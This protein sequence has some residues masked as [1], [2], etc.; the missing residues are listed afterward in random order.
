MVIS[1]LLYFYLFDSHARD[2]NGMPDPNGT[3]VV[4]KF[5][6]ALELEQYLY[7]LSIKLHANLYEIVPV[8]VN[9]S[10][11]A[12]QIL[13]KG[14]KDQQYHNCS[15]ENKGDKGA[16]LQEES[17][18]ANECKKRW[19]ANE[20]DL[21]RQN[22]LERDRLHKKLKRSQETDYEKQIRL[23]KNRLYKSKRR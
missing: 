16:T 3:A 11:T 18:K 23:E 20:T 21:Q 6:N 13:S 10:T 15:P 12:Q 5:N 9:K 19:K 14:T 1:W 17:Q 22:R 2:F 7:C 4:M 8:K